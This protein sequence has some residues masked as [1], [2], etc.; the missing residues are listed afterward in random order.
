MYKDLNVDPEKLR[1]TSGLGAGNNDDAI[2]SVM[3]AQ[4]DA[5]C[6]QQNNPAFKP[7]EVALQKVRTYMAGGSHGAQPS[8]ASASGNPPP[9]DTSSGSASGTP[10][11][12]SPGGGGGNSSGSSAP[13]DNASGTP[14]SGPSGTGN[15]SGSDNSASG[16]GSS[17]TGSGGSGTPGKVKSPLSNPECAGVYSNKSC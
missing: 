1:K 10:S 5:Q 17:A 7:Y 12:S 9:A 14:S 8:G 3:Q 11:A 4:I 6:A 15:S 2:R 13:T 16:S